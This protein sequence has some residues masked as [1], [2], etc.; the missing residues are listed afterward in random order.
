MVFNNSEEYERLKKEVAKAQ[1]TYDEF[2]QTRDKVNKALLKAEDDIVF[3]REQLRKAQDALTLFE[4]TQM[5]NETDDEEF[6]R[7]EIERLRKKLPELLKRVEA[8]DERK[9]Q[10]ELSAK[11]DDFDKK[12]NTLTTAGDTNDKDATTTEKIV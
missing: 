5:D 3:S 1:A 9:K 4:N 12:L 11:L 2:K 8:E 6:R 10:R 7:K